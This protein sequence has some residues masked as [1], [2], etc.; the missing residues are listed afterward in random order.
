MAEQ[1]LGDFYGSCDAMHRE[2]YS[3]LIREWEELGLTWSWSGRAIA[4]GSNSVIKDEMLIFFHLQ[5]GES[6]Y[7]ATISIDTDAWR[8]RLGQ[9]E[10]DIFLRDIKA[11]PGLQHKQ[12]EN[13]FSIVDAGH[14]SGPTQQRLRDMI[15]HLGFRIPE[16]T[17]R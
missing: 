17:A 3:V 1:T 12:R 4:L 11:I 5:P 9:E 15:K 6:I 7:P 8:E 2:F 10:T 16:L 13:I 14:L